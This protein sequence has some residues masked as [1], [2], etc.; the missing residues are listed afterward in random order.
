[1]QFD[2]YCAPILHLAGIAI[3]I[4]PTD[5]EGHARRHIEE[6]DTLPP[7]ILVAGGDG[8]VSETITGLLRRSGGA[9]ATTP[10]GV[11]PCGR[12]NTLAQQL[13]GFSNADSVREVEGMAA[14]AMAIVRGKLSDTDVIKIEPIVDVVDANEPPAARPI[15]AIGSIQWGAFRDALQK[16]DKY[17]YF[18]SLRDYTAYLFNALSG[19]LTW[20]CAAQL[21]YSPPCAG[22]SNCYQLPASSVAAAAMSSGSSRR[23]AAV[24]AGGSRR[25]WSGY[26]APKGGAAN[27]GNNNGNAA[28]PVDYARVQNPGCRSA[29]Q[30][31]VHEHELLLRNNA[32]RRADEVPRLHIQLNGAGLSAVDFVTEGWSRIRREASA[33]VAAAERELDV[34]A[35][36]I[37]PAAEALYSEEREV[38]FSIDN[39]A[40]EVKPVRVSVVPRAVR[41]Y[42]T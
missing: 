18:G 38:F 3:E 16:R 31:E 7:A 19:R 8:T 27:V 28:A 9:A 25:W 22:C 30:L 33:A 42:T 13:F 40:Y 1:M 10:I 21:T 14:A 4:L 11:L 37:R 5:S 17:W 26:A 35:V 6:L 15:F 34:R 12:T 2:E 29:A 36:E 20:E 32:R 23:A 24:S 39:E 41:L